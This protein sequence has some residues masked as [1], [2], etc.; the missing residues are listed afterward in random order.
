MSYCRRTFILRECQMLP[1]G[2][3]QSNYRQ[4]GQ[5]ADGPSWRVAIFTIQFLSVSSISTIM[6]RPTTTAMIADSPDLQFMEITTGPKYVQTRASWS[7]LTFQIVLPQK[8]FGPRARYVRTH[9]QKLVSLIFISERAAFTNGRIKCSFFEIA[10][11]QR[12][13]HCLFSTLTGIYFF[14]CPVTSLLRF[15]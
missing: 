8:C 14:G 2:L 1:L 5:Q 15:P 9:A 11:D 7:S 6:P 4:T 3:L 10:V 13:F 12:Q